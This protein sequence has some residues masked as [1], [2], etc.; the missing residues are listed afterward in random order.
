MLSGVLQ[1]SVLGPVLCYISD[2]PEM[3]TS[4]IYLYADD[5][6]LFRRINDDCDRA[7]LQKDLDHLS[8]WSEQW[9]LRFN[10]DK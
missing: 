1:G 10:V 6:K 9:Q 2:M 3:I 7:A 5:T 8:T 4:I